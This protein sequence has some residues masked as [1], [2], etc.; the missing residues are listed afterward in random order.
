MKWSKLLENLSTRD[1]LD[2]WN[3]PV[4]AVAMFKM[5]VKL[6]VCTIIGKWSG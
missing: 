1:R 5:E 2:F 3:D 6:K 4:E